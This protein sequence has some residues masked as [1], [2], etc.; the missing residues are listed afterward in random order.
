MV[1]ASLFDTS[2][3]Q[4]IGTSTNVV[5]SQFISA[6]VISPITED[7][8]TLQGILQRREQIKTGNQTL[9]IR[10]RSTLAAAVYA[11]KECQFD[12]VVCERDLSPGSWKEVLEEIFNLPDPPPLIVISQLAD[13]RLW[14]EALNLGAFDVLAKPL[15]CIETTRVFDAACRST[16]SLFRVLANENFTG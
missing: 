3:G 16:R 4:V 11:L 15:D 5:D 6:L 8:P 14:A 10:F 7:H 9:T 2:K 13:A 12:V 1:Q